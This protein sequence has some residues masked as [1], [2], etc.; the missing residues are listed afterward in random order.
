MS[1]RKEHEPASNF[2]EYSKIF[3]DTESGIEKNFP[4]MVHF[5]EV[6]NRK[7]YFI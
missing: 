2:N 4:N 6:K 3:N 7:N 1:K 5:P